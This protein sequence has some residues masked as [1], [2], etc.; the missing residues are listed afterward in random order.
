MR[1]LSPV[2]IHEFPLD[3]NPC[4][5][6]SVRIFDALAPLANSV[7]VP[8]RTI[9]AATNPRLQFI[10]SPRLLGTYLTLF[11]LTEV[12]TLLD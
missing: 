8:K 1:F 4:S 7:A 5:F 3:G 6:Y 2:T 9:C 10:Q 11:R 12:S